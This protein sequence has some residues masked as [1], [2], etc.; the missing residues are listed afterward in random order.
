MGEREGGR[1]GGKK[2]G[3]KVGTEEEKVQALEK[4]K[5]IEQHTHYSVI[6]FPRSCQHVPLS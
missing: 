2:E 6:F 3:R 1:E 4:K 5:E